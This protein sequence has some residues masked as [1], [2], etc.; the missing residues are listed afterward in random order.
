MGDVGIVFGSRIA[1]LTRNLRTCRV[2][3]DEAARCVKDTTEQVTPVTAE[4]PDAAESLNIEF[5]RV[6]ESGEQFFAV[7]D[8]LEQLTQKV[9]IPRDEGRLAEEAIL[10]P[11]RLLLEQTTLECA[12]ENPI[13]LGTKIPE[14]EARSDR[15][16]RLDWNGGNDW[17]NLCIRDECWSWRSSRRNDAGLACGHEQIQRVESAIAAQRRSAVEHPRSEEREECASG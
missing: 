2:A 10:T 15:V 12:K 9:A 8:V 3:V 6:N 5:E 7:H 13:D 4:V 1:M 16:S 17:I 14:S 11:E